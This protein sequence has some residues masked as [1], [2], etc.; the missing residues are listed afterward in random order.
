MK[1]KS[2]EASVY[3]STVAYVASKRQTKAALGA[4]TG[5]TQYSRDTDFFVKA[6]ATCGCPAFE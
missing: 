2:R 3:T 1:G 5:K 6:N 4:I